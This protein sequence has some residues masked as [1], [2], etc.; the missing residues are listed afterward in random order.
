MPKLTKVKSHGTNVH[1]IIDAHMISVDAQ[2]KIPT[3]TENVKQSLDQT[4]E[5]FMHGQLV[6]IRN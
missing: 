6:K 5:H 4:V 2:T 3:D 1:D